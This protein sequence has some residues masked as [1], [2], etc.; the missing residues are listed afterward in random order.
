MVFHWLRRLVRGP[1]CSV[2]V[3]TLLWR[4]V[5][6]RK[7]V[8]VAAD[9][10]VIAHELVLLLLEVLHAR[11]VILR[12]IRW[13]S[14]LCLRMHLPARF[15]RGTRRSLLLSVH[16]GLRVVLLLVR[17]HHCRRVDSLVLMRAKFR[18]QV[19]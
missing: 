12:L 8:S 4:V 17:C 11:H 1:S 2:Q 14:L 19:A 9:R 15:I 16:R 5:Y 13:C 18:V 3:V 6:S 7:H 10:G